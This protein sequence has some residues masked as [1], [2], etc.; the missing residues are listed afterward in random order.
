MLTVEAYDHI[1]VTRNAILVKESRS[2]ISQGEQLQLL[3]HL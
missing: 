3:P 1:F 2:E